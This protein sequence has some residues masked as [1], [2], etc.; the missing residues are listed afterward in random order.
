VA[1]LC[2]TLQHNLIGVVLTYNFN[3]RKYEL[4]NPES[5]VGA[6][7]LIVLCL[8]TMSLP[9]QST[10][11]LHLLSTNHKCTKPC[12]FPLLLKLAA[13]KEKMDWNSLTRSSRLCVAPVAIPVVLWSLSV[14]RFVESHL[15]L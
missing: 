5:C 1:I 6:F 3:L 11:L 10:Y 9:L 13:Q 2:D 15:T 8:I 4:L 7:L 14:F 12:Y